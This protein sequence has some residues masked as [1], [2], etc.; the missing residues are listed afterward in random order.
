MLAGHQVTPLGTGDR[1]VLLEDVPALRGKGLEDPAF[2]I[3]GAPEVVGL[4]VDPDEHFVQMP[5]PERVASLLM[6]VPLPDLR[7]EHR[8]EP[9]PPEP[10]GLVADVYAALEQEILDLPK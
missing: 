2:V 4:A 5:S 9:G 1:A 7:G 3:H 8:T 6:N 10:H